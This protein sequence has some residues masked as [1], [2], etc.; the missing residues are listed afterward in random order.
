VCGGHGTD[1]HGRLRIAPFL[2]VPANA[3]EKTL[4]NPESWN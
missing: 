3:I 2:L 4:Q 1:R